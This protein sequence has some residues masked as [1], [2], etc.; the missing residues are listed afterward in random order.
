MDGEGMTWR[1]NC[2]YGCT[3]YIKEL[4]RSIE[5][6]RAVETWDKRSLVQ[7][8]MV[9]IRV[10][11]SESFEKKRSWNDSG[12]VA[13]EREKIFWHERKPREA[14]NQVVIRECI[15]NFRAVFSSDYSVSICF[16][17]LESRME[18]EPKREAER[19]LI[20]N[21]C[22]L[23]D[24]ES[25]K[26]RN[27]PAH[28]FFLFFFLPQKPHY[29]S[30]GATETRRAPAP[31]RPFL[32]YRV[33]KLGKWRSGEKLREDLVFGGKNW[34][35]ESVLLDSMRFSVLGNVRWVQMR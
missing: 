30:K 31:S 35:K 18:H 6:V 33:T 1:D 8:D 20:A 24:G 34:K 16:P 12:T 28:V 17:I 2:T 9:T 21:L 26:F 25:D 32:E 29:L 10:R 3:E 14:E 5:R 23:S 11:F 19:V 15:R 22:I 27:V 13:F 7:R 4:G